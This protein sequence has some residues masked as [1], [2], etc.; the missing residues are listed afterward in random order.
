[1]LLPAPPVF[2]CGARL[3]GSVCAAAAADHGGQLTEI[4]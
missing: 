4:C 3:E 1:M 2:F